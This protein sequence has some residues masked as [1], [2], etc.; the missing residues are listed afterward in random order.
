[1]KDQNGHRIPDDLVLLENVDVTVSQAKKIEQLDWYYVENNGHIYVSDASVRH[2]LGGHD[3]LPIRD[4][5]PIIN[6]IYRIDSALKRWD[7]E[8]GFWH[9]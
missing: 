2:I 4:V 3:F 1:M 7:I 5:Y 6:R 9:V 8:H